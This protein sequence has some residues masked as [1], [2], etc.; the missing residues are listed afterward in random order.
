LKRTTL[1][2]PLITCSHP[3]TE[4]HH[5]SNEGDFCAFD[6]QDGSGGQAK[7]HGLAWNISPDFGKLKKAR[8]QV[9]Y[10]LMNIMIARSD[11]SFDPG[12]ITTP[13]NL[14]MELQCNFVKDGFPPVD[15]L[16]IRRE[17]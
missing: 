12:H 15:A 3:A 17:A 8:Y 14:R 16:I 5:L 10:R 6:E 2:T 13:A 11:T 1:G 7:G 4:K 9:G